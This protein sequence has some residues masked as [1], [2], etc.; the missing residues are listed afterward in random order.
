M[1]Q[2]DPTPRPNAILMILIV[3]S[4]LLV[5]GFIFFLYGASR[6]ESG[7]NNAPVPYLV[8]AR[9]LP[10]ITNIRD[11]FPQTLGTFAR[12]TISGDLSGSEAV[13][14]GAS[15]TS[16]KNTIKINGVR[17]SNTAQ[18]LNDFN[19]QSPTVFGTDRVSSTDRSFA[20]VMATTANGNVRIIYARSFWLFD[21]TASSRPALDEFM[22]VFKY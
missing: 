18:M 13:K 2:R 21:V 5:G 9:P 8:N 16:G 22:K 6:S 12:K 17:E 19:Q 20:Y 14:F 1:A 4:I 7:G 3:V 11:V 15:Y 10:A